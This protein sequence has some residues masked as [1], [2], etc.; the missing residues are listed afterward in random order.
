MKK[1]ILFTYLL[2]SFS[3]VNAQNKIRFIDE[4]FL[5]AAKITSNI[6]YGSNIDY[7][8]NNVNLTLDVYEPT[9]DTMVKR[10]LIIMAHEGSFLFGSK[11]DDYMIKYAKKMV[12]RGYVVACITYRK[13]WAPNP[14][15]SAEDNSRLILPAAWR[16][17][18][19][20]KAATR[21]FRKDAATTNTYKIDPNRIAGGGFGA[22]AYLSINGQLIDESSE[23]QLACLRQKD[24][25]GNPT[26]TPYIDTTKV[27]L[28]GINDTKSGSPGYSWRLPIT[29]IYSGAI[30]DT[31]LMNAGQNPKAIAA[32]GEK[33]ETTPYKIAIVN[34]Q[35]TPDVL[36]PIIKVYGTYQVTRVLEK[37]GVNT[38]FNNINQD[39]FPQYNVA[40]TKFGPLNM[41][42]KGVYT[43]LNQTYMPWDSLQDGYEQSAKFYMDTLV[44]YTAPRLAFAFGLVNIKDVNTD[45]TTNGIFNW[46]AHSSN[47]EMY[48]NPTKGKI[49]ID[50]KENKTQEEAI[51]YVY[52]SIGQELKIIKIKVDENSSLDLSDL[53]KGVYFVKLQSSK[54]ISTNKLIIE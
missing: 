27:D 38:I 31:V 34:A 19:D 39:K 54:G 3:I 20:F 6:Q 5:G 40:D 49:N 47:F 16:A 1:L 17:V 10:P 15:G 30:V 32:H 2:F 36:I 45:S 29:L 22:G 21:F 50:L 52:N 43:F 28:G 41:Y 12:K 46:N 51:I 18:Q 24:G 14:A 37:I 25:N 4:V 7:T 23:F 48:P 35:V 53:K 26:N 9:P 11:T 13:G 42:K 44:R 33:D 8:G